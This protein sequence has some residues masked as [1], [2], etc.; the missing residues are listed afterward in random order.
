MTEAEEIQ[1]S[2]AEKIAKLLRLAENTANEEEADAFNAKAQALMVKYAVSE[3][4]LAKANGWQVQDTI[5]QSHIAY[6]GIFH[7]ALF[8]IGRAVAINN[9]CKHLISRITGKSETHLLLV[10]FTRDIERVKLLDT[11]LQMQASAAMRR[12]YKQQDVVW[13]TPMQK[14]KIRREFL[15]GFAN[16]VSFKLK[17]ARE[18][19]INEA[20]QDESDRSGVAAKDVAASTALV[21][22]TKDEQVQDWVDSYYGKSLRSVKRNYSS[23]GY[24]AHSAGRTAGQNA[25]TGQ[26]GL[27][28]GPQGA[29]ER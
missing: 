10:G 23:G 2:Y 21:L 22:R 7:M 27:G 20:V 28:R 17:R 12:W 4:L 14:A 29:I 6:T 8:D 13:M 1:Q 11:S 24:A 16:G 5:E 15:F 26:T 19:G 9:D 3:Q 25:N 18:A